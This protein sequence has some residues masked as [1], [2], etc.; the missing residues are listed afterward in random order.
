MIWADSDDLGVG[1][2]GSV[3]NNEI[4]GSFLSS[5]RL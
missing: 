1:G 5:L 2:K 4:A 3:R